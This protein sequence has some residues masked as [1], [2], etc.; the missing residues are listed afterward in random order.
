MEHKPDIARRKL[1]SALGCGLAAATVAALPAQ[2]KD[3]SSAKGKPRFTMIMDSRK[4]IGCMACVAACK[5]ENNI[6]LGF[7]RT[8][9]QDTERG[10]YPNTQRVFVPQLCN[11]CEDAPCIPVCPADATFRDAD[12]IVVIDQ[13]ECIGCKRCVR[14]CPY[15]ARYM[16]PVAE[17]ADKCDLCENRRQSGLLPACVEVCPTQARVFGEAGSTQGTFGR[18]AARTDLKVL[19]PEKNTQPAVK[20]VGI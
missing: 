10:A 16:N 14:A 9:V 1:F 19:Q 15:G 17:V 4:C 7:S 13:S 3:P 8:H 11:Q 2:A 12:G 6:P 20:Y 18:L 5:A